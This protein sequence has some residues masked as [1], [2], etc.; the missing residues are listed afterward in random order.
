MKQIN[1]LF[2]T[3]WLELLAV[4]ALAL[5][6]TSNANCNSTNKKLSFADGS[7]ACL[8]EFGF[9][10]KQGLM[11]SIPNESYATK[12]QKH[13]SFAIAV[14][15]QPMFCPFE[16]SM[17]WGDFN[18]GTRWSANPIEAREAVRSCEN[19][20][21]AAIQIFG[22]TGDVQSCKCEVLVESGTVKMSRSEFEQK[23]KT[24]ERQI[25][26]G[27]RPIQ[28]VEA[29][30]KEQA[31]REAEVKRLAEAK[32]RED[33]RLV[34]MKERA[35]REAREE[36]ER[37]KN[38]PPTVFAMRRALL[39]GNDTYKYADVLKNAREDA[40]AMANE[41]KG[42][43]YEVTLRL[44]QNQKEMQ[45]T[46]RDFRES[47]KEGDEVLFYFSGHAVEIDGKNYLTPIDTIGMNQNQL[48][49]DSIDLK[50]SVLD[51]FTRKKAKLTLALIDACR[52]NPFLKTSSTRSVVGGSKGLAPTTPATGQLIV[53]SAGSGQTA[54]D[55]LGES[56]NVKNGLF[57]RVF[58]QEMKK[59][60]LPIDRVIKNVR[61]EVVRLARTIGHDQ[62]PAIYD[63]VVGDFYFKK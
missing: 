39:I 2:T 23:T 63:E 54:L 1:K 30:L 38:A 51:P 8:E 45:A 12:S 50:S 21:N 6:L 14:T 20:M 58:L 10:N 52:N 33:D 47:I 5:P 3:H 35:E 59:V 55:R 16:Q 18:S 40:R 9:L 11:K 31:D 44:D 13:I 17:Q 41:L 34:A 7:V 15:A 46:L 53:Y 48:A 22:K 37:K 56:D 61:T 60:D 19:K 26:L 28:I 24:Y 62:V 42:F 49:D 4:I 32:K 25:A 57:T 36:A 29:Q 43:G 27:L